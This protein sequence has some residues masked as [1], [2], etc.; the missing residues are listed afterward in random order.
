[1]ASHLAPGGCATRTVRAIGT[2]AVVAITD[3]ARAE[4]ALEQLTADLA[5]LDAACSRFRPDSELRR[6]ERSA[7]GRPIAVSAL[8]YEV[9]EVGCSVA[10]LTA[11]T[12]DPTVG[13][14]L[15]ALGYDRDF[16][17]V[18]SGCRGATAAPA[19]APGWW[20][21]TLD[22]ECRTASIPPGVHVDVGA[23]AKAFA[24][25]RSARTIAAGTG[26]GVLVNLGGDVAVAGPPPDGG[27]PVGIAPHCSALS[28][29]VQEVVSVLAGG[30]AT[31]GTTWRT[32]SG[33]GRPVHHIVDPSTG[34]PAAPVWSLVSVAAASCVEANA[35]S[36]AAVV[37]G[38]DAPG[39]LAGCGVSAR[40]VRAHGG[41]RRVGDWPVPTASS[42]H[43]VALR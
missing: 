43:P 39:H 32:W 40:L 5:A 4:D 13:S 6:L 23:S 11:G 16:E 3:A 29:E 34:E 1:M 28:S 8:L 37:W 30:L 21:I 24:A 20:T 38:E 33:G 25:D 19:P 10:A 26:E 9:L 27:W 22:P 15:V 31:S 35:F 12:V 42:R 2:T 36:T 41:I 17:E 14:A 7:T 18:R